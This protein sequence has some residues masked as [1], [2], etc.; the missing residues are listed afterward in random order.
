MNEPP[1]KTPCRPQSSGLPT[2]GKGVRDA[3]FLEAPMLENFIVSLASFLN[4]KR[5]VSYRRAKIY[6]SFGLHQSPVTNSI[7]F[8][9]TVSVTGDR[10]YTFL[11]DCISHR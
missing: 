1:L 5:Y 9:R 6:F 3:P 10:Q 4:I 11:L 8:V 7:L 2:S